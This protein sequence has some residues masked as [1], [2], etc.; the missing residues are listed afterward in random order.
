[1]FTLFPSLG[2]FLMQNL[3]KK[4]K[5]KMH[6]VVKLIYYYLFYLPFWHPNLLLD[7]KVFVTVTEATQF[8]VTAGSTLIQISAIEG[9]RPIT[10]LLYNLSVHIH[11]T[12]KKADGQ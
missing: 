5:F 7:T 12:Q 8:C 1:M 6:F 11:C 4:L 9:F 10:K 3:G 2:Y